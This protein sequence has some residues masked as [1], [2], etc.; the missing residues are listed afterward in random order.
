[1]FFKSRYLEKRSTA[2]FDID[3]VVAANV[4]AETVITSINAMVYQHECLPY[5]FCEGNRQAKVIGHGFQYA[6]PLY[7]YFQ[8]EMSM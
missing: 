8:Y 2:E 4:L 3:R 7:R 1:M 6:M 5:I